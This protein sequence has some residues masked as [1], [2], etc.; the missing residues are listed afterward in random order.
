MNNPRHARADA[1][2]GFASTD[3]AFTHRILAL[4]AA[5]PGA[6]RSLVDLRILDPGSGR[7]LWSNCIRRNTSASAF[8]GFPSGR[9]PSRLGS[10]PCRQLSRPPGPLRPQVRSKAERA[11]GAEA[12]KSCQGWAGLAGSAG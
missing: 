8:A 1:E 2:A 9:R 12:G 5:A 4:P 7:A 3:Q 11:A 10:T 6:A